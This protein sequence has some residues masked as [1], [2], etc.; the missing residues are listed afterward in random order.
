MSTTRILPIDH[1]RERRNRR[2]RLARALYRAD[3]ERGRVLEHLWETA[4]LVGADR[5]ALVWVDEY[6]PGLVHV[7]TLLDLLSDT[8]RR[9]F[10]IDA[11]R[12]A[13]QRGVPGVID[14][15]EPERDRV[16]P[17]QNPVRS[18]CVVALGSDGVKAWFLVVDAMQ[19]R[20][21]FTEEVTGDLMFHAGE[22]AA[23]VLHRDLEPGRAGPTEGQEAS[24]SGGGFQGWPVLRDIEGG[25]QDQDLSR[26]IS[27]RFLVTRVLRTVVEDDMEVDMESL[28]SQIDGV[29]REVGPW[30]GDAEG[31]AWERILGAAEGMDRQELCAA[32]LAL[33]VQV[34]ER[35]HLNGA[36]ELYRTSYELSMGIAA[37]E[38]SLEA[39]RFL[40]RAC[41]RQGDWEEAAHWYEVARGI[42]GMLGDVAKEAAILDGMSNLHR[43]R[44]NMPGA[45]AILEE[46]LK[47]AQASRNRYAL[48]VIHH[49][50]MGLERTAGQVEQAVRHGWR[51]V[52]EYDDDENRLQALTS[53]AGVFVELGDLGAAEDAYTIVAARVRYSAYRIAALVSLAHI[54]A[55][56]GRRDEFGRRKAQAEQAGMDDA[57][58]HV[59]AECM[60]YLGL[61]WQ[62]LGEPGPA[63]AWFERTLSYAEA[64]RVTRLVFLAEKALEDS[65][66]A[67][68][69]MEADV[70]DLPTPGWLE[71]MQGIRHELSV[72]RSE[73]VALSGA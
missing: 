15:P 51:A 9:A 70:V 25:E 7:H 43:D 39:G 19:P 4:F 49:S 50:L 3:R 6:G 66:A 37:A 54:A 20:A 10:A 57:P 56:Q 21:P 31:E 52:S 65:G 46:G 68:A 67:E 28:Q 12:S 62:A 22:C 23:V 72:M 17:L 40:A 58:V 48:G 34:E 11:L 69:M 53:L 64:H 14:M 38:V 63:R 45:R 26:R 33:A 44:G 47:L 24:A 71:E 59:R 16:V 35:G 18:S 29:R 27:A 42:A 61:G 30:E 41:R 60:Y 5:A 8:P 1:Y 2:L 36:R 55:L 13:W 73:A 32:T